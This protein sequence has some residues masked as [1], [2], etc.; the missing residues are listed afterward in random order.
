MHP[1]WKPEMIMVES[2]NV[3]DDKND[4]DRTGLCIQPRNGQWLVTLKIE[5]IKNPSPDGCSIVD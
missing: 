1:P 3:D 5:I 4:E 2:E